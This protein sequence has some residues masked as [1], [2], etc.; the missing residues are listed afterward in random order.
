MILSTIGD[1]SGKKGAGG[2]INLSALDVLLS[3]WC[4][5]ALRLFF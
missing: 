5:A 4:I 1:I 2:T 3:S